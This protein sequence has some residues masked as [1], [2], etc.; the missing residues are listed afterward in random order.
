MRS[1]P[2]PRIKLLLGI[3]EAPK[4]L[5][6][7]QVTA[8]RVLRKV[9]PGADVTDLSPAPSLCAPHPRLYAHGSNCAPRVGAK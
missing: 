9:T 1:C 3:P 5:K 6:C 4:N 7:P 8:E 2:K